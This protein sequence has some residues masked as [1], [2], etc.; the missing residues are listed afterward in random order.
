MAY[1]RTN[2]ALGVNVVIENIEFEQIIVGDDG[3][4]LND[5]CYVHFKCWNHNGLEI[6]GKV[7]VNT[8]AYQMAI[9]ELKENIRI[10]VLESV[11]S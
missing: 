2:Q 10:A 5:A 1:Y 7:K 9:N 4:T 6:T 8:E 11:K 3:Q